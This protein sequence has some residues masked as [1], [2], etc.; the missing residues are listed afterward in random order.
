MMVGDKLFATQITATQRYTQAP[1]RY[2]EA[3][4]V[5]RLEELGIGRPSTYAPTITTI[6]NRGYVVKQNRDAQRRNLEQMILT[7][8]KIATK[9]TSESYGKEKNRLAPTDIGMVV[10]D[11]LETQFASIIDYHFTANVEKEE[12]HG[13]LLYGPVLTLDILLD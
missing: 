6:I 9:Q 1:S 8:G 5:K 3:A 10:N 2:N 13:K 7:G 11:Y 12:G 4:L